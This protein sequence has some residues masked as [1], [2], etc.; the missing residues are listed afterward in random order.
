MAEQK[1]IYTIRVVYDNG[2]THDFDVYSFD[3]KNGEYTWEAVGNMNKPI[4]LGVDH[5]IAVYQIGYKR[6]FP[7]CS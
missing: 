7:V 5:I 1:V 3:V 2:Y 6:V 4:I